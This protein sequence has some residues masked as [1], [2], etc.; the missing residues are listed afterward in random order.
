MTFSG[1]KGALRK[2]RPSHTGG[3]HRREEGRPSLVAVNPGD[4]LGIAQAKGRQFIAQNPRGASTMVVGAALGR[5]DHRRK[6]HEYE[7]QSHAAAHRRP[8]VIEPQKATEPDDDT[9]LFAS[10]A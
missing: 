6:A 5:G 8:F 10:F 9:G 4:D 3:R 1:S 2:T 7:A